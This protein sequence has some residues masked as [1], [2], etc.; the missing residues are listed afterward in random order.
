[1]EV[2]EQI[3]KKVPLFTNPKF[4]HSFREIVLKKKMLF[5]SG[6]QRDARRIILQNKDSKPSHIW[7]RVSIFFVKDPAYATEFV[8]NKYLTKKAKDVLILLAG[9]SRNYPQH[10]LDSLIS[11]YFALCERKI[12]MSHPSYTICEKNTQTL[13]NLRSCLPKHLTPEN[14]DETQRGIKRRLS[15]VQRLF[16]LRRKKESESTDKTL[17][18]INSMSRKTSDSSELSTNDSPSGFPFLFS[19]RN[20]KAH[21]I[22]SKQPS[23]VGNSN[24]VF[25]TP[26]TKKIKKRNIKS[27]LKNSSSRVLCL[28]SRSCCSIYSE[29]SEM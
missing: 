22:L 28:R 14:V 15:S 16:S 9:L 21:C 26:I 19:K 13:N 3:E 23:F 10:P 6:K 5:I 7:E 4:F 2:I 24:C 20:K 27:S 11:L 18:L 25:G 29:K 1:M 12:K 8:F 17:P